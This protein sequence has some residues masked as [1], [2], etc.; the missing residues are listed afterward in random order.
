MRPQPAA[1]DVLMGGQQEDGPVLQ[2]VL[3][4]VG[5]LGFKAFLDLS[6]RQAAAG[7]DEAGMAPLAGPVVAAISLVHDRHIVMKYPLQRHSIHAMMSL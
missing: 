7:I 5:H 2:A 1:A 3:F 6:L 4:L